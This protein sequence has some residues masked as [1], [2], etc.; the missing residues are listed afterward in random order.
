M[1]RRLCAP[2][3]VGLAGLM[4][5]AGCQSGGAAPP[6]LP[7]P[8]PVED[9][10]EGGE[11]A[12][13]SAAGAFEVALDLGGLRL[14]DPQTGSTRP[15]AFGDAEGAVV[16]AVARSAGEPAE[17]GVNDECGAGPLSYA[18][19]SDG[20]TL[21]F[22]DGA[23]AG[24]AVDGRS[25]GSER[26]TTMTGLGIGAT[27]ADLDRAYAADVGPSSLGT[28]FA[29]GDLGGVLDG[30]G[31]GARVTDLWGGTTCAFR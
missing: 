9:D 16:R 21:W 20:L 11:A 14:V 6:V 12:S 23:F 27:R 22:S 17:R 18:S 15:V 26:L 7:S 29:A 8:P 30:S 1:L 24:W 5:L 28:E 10:S 3:V 13:P 2:L 25:S 19:W 31:P 4:A